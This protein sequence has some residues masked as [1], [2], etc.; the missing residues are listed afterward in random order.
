[1]ANRSGGCTEQPKASL[2][3]I[4]APKANNL[5]IA[6]VSLMIGRLVAIDPEALP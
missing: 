1:M 2:D 6:D 3:G 5:S 4:E